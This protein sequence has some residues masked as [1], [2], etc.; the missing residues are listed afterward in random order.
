ML[1]PSLLLRSLIPIGYMPMFGSGFSVGL[2]LCPAYAPI[3]AAIGGAAD[4]GRQTAT[5]DATMD[6]SGMDMPMDMSMS[7]TPQPSPSVRNADA[8]GGTS[9]GSAPSP[10]GGS[11]HQDHTLCPYAASATLGAPPASYGPAVNGQ[12]TAHYTLFAPQ[13]AYFQLAARAQSAR[14][15]PLIPS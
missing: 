11:G 1:L 4:P 10:D 7:G 5:A 13:V 9:H 6:M 8:G 2:M 15:P 3:P 14:G 12:S